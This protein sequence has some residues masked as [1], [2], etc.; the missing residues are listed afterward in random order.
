MYFEEHLCNK[1]CVKFS[2]VFGFLSAN[3]KLNYNSKL[4]LNMYKHG[5]FVT[6]NKTQTPD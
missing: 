1:P 5:H 6:S 2:I 4:K 3:N